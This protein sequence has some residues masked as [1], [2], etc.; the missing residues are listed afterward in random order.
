MKIVIDFGH[1]AHVHYFK[2]FIKEM[3]DNGHEIMCFARERYP[4]QELLNAYGIEVINRGRGS[5]KLVGKA[6][7][8]FRVVWFIYYHSRKFK[9]DILMSFSGIYTTFAAVLLGAKAISLDD[10]ETASKVHSVCKPF[11]DLILT[12]ECYKLD[13]GRKHV[14]FPGTLDMAYL[15]PNRFTPNE[16]VLDELGLEISER[17]AIVRFVSWQAHHDA[18]CK[19]LSPDSKRKLVTHLAAKMKVFISSESELPPDLREYEIKI[20]P[21]H[22]HSVL[23][24]ATIF[25]GESGSMTTECAVLGTPNIHVRHTIDPRL[26]PGVHLYFKN[27]DVKVLCEASNI[28]G[29]I[30][31]IDTMTDHDF[32]RKQFIPAHSMLLAEAIDLTAFF[33]WFIENYPRTRDEI[34]SP[35]WSYDRFMV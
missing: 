26:V 32:A 19:G 13:L 22:M 28:D 27:H 9:P 5:N 14:K 33:V 3:T 6:L 4:I 2:H 18:G 20:K 21:E 8:F 12:P 7:N 24:F 16:S 25:I 15:H 10:T 35:D 34:L 17:F 23:A 30:D 1:P 11:V 31:R 29:I